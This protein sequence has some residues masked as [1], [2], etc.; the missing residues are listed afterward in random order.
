MA[1]YGDLDTF[2]LKA[3]ADLSAKRYHIMRASAEGYCNMASHS[4]NSTMIGVLINDPQANGHATIAYEGKSKVVA[5]AAVSA[6]AFITTNGSGR[7][8]AVASGG[9]ACGRALQAASADGEVITC[10]LFP[11][12]RWAGAI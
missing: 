9:M 1:E 12:I 7:A 2:T 10:Q 5:G 11:P 8:V 4:T 6:N 3:A